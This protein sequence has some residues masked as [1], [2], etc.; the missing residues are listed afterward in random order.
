MTY[1]IDCLALAFVLFYGIVLARHIPERFH[2]AA[3]IL[4]SLVAI[5]WGVRY[6]LNFTDMGL[7]IQ[8]V[9]RGIL[10]AAL[11][12]LAI[13]II[14]ALAAILTPLKHIVELP[15][16]QKSGQ[17]AYETAVR[18]PLSTALSEEILFRGVLLATLMHHFSTLLSAIVVSIVFGLWHVVPTLRDHKRIAI[19][20]T[21]IATSA[22]GFI[23][24]WLRLLAGSIIAPWLVHWT[25]NASAL[26]ALHVIHKRHAFKTQRVD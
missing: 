14:A 24:C 16:V 5:L 8:F 2:F 19:A 25:I 1:I 3:N 10:V 18:I 26:L 13:M 21:I 20:P 4:V 23:F 17:I 12:S 9:P 11:A 15:Q 6:G 7:S 22:T